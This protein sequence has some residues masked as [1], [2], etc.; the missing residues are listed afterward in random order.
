MHRAKILLPAALAAVGLCLCV[1][2][3]PASIF[4]DTPASAD[5]SKGKTVEKSPLVDAKV[6]TFVPTSKPA[7]AKKFY[8]EILGLKFLSEDDFASTFEAGKSVLRLQTVKDLKPHSFTQTGWEVTKIETVV[9][10]LSKRGVKFEN[11][12][13]PFQDKNGIAT[14]PGGDKVAWFK[15]PDGNILSLAELAGR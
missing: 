9:A 7:E 3:I 11:Y 14:F 6:M 10:D 4:D 1:N 2:G 8:A 12:N 5:K 13:L 15:D